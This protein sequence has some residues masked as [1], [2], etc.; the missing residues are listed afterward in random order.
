M[1]AALGLSQDVA[2]ATFMAAGSSAPELVT[3]FLGKY[4]SLYFLLTQCDFIFFKSGSTNVAITL[5]IGVFIT[6]GDIGISTILGSAMY[7]LFGICAACGLLSNV[8]R[9][10]TLLHKFIVLTHYKNGLWSRTNKALV[11]CSIKFINQ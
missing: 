4:R 8:V 2:G 1:S 6:K 11:M 3:A 9:K 10:T 7:N 5:L